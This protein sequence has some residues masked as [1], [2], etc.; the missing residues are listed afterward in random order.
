MKKTIDILLA[1]AM[2]LPAVSCSEW[3]EVEVLGGIHPTEGGEFTQYIPNEDKQAYYAALREYKKTDHPISFG[4]YSSWAPV[5]NDSFGIGPG[6]MTGL[7]DSLD[8]VSLWLV[9]PDLNK[10][11]TEVQKRDL[12]MA[13]NERGLKV[14]FCLVEANL[15]AQITPA[16]PEGS[17]LSTDAWRQQ[18]WKVDELGWEEA[19][20]Q[21]GL[22]LGKWITEAGYDGF[23][24]DFEPNF[25]HTG[26][27]ASY[28]ARVQRFLEGMSEYFGP[29][30]RGEGETVFTHGKVLMVDGEPQTLNS[31][32]GRLIDYYN[33]Q[34][35]YCSGYSNL[36]TRFRNLINKFGP[37]TECNETIEEIHRKVIW[38]E[39]FENNSYRDG[40]ANF[41]KRN[42]G[43]CKSLYGMSTWHYPGYE[44]VRIG[45][46]GAF[47]FNLVYERIPAG[48]IYGNWH[49]IR[50]SI[51]AMNPART[52]G[53]Q[54][55]ED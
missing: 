3:T 23:D 21:Y 24:Y 50:E 19:S 46:A 20:Y 54:E 30:A 31:S 13:R 45:G 9:Y 8:M 5:E 34:A 14:L 51:Q 15:G 27:L 16:Q 29:N 43:S 33:I 42:G 53:K 22:A 25:G 7:P 49:Y 11:L 38:C 32:L 1:A 36:D 17:E 41:S 28:P 2:L 6:S 26:T 39:D 4:W 10:D 47:K 35:Y 40:G 37:G 52:D 18:Y 48:S 12:D 55:Q 44:D